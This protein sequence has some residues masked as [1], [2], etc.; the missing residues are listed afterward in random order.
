M[1]QDRSWGLFWQAAWTT[2]GDLELRFSVLC[3][4]CWHRLQIMKDRVCLLLACC[5]LLILSR[6]IRGSGYAGSQMPRHK[7]AE[8]LILLAFPFHKGV[9]YI[10]PRLELLPPTFRSFLSSRFGLKNYILPEFE[11]FLSFMFCFPLKWK[12][13]MLQL[14]EKSVSDSRKSKST[15]THVSCWCG[16]SMSAPFDTV[17]PFS[18]GNT[19]GALQKVWQWFWSR[20]W[21]LKAKL[22]SIWKEKTRHIWGKK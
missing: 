17:C 11:L 19:E 15:V 4:L 6:W 18:S 3:W 12:H 9:F 21:I 16:V 22:F 14:M 20:P 2:L 5:M 7:G 13:W 8:R 10:V 1:C